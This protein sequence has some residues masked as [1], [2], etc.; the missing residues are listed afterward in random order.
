MGRRATTGTLK[1]D[2]NYRGKIYGTR[3]GDRQSPHVITEQT[4]PSYCNRPV[5]R[6]YLQTATDPPTFVL[7]HS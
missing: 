1:M 2:V 4:T 3:R 7:A 5:Q 6:Q